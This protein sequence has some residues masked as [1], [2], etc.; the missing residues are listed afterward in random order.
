MDR[1]VRHDLLLHVLHTVD[2]VRVLCLVFGP[3]L[4]V[5]T[6]ACAARGVSSSG[7]VRKAGI[8]HN[9][10]VGQVLPG[11]R[12]LSSRASH[13]SGIAG[14]DIL[15]REHGGSFSGG[16]RE[17]VGENLGGGEGP[18]R[19]ALLL[20][21]DGMDESLP[22]IT[23]IE[24]VGDGLDGVVSGRMSGLSQH[25]TSSGGSEQGTSV[26]EGHVSEELVVSSLPGVSI[27]VQGINDIRVV[28]LLCL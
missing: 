23:S 11:V 16:N 18:A 8:G 21:S 1:S 4:T 6:F 20:I 12:K 25:H 10:L 24:G 13:I 9:T 7:S 5:R 26:G 17:S 27:L 22:M 14:H 28:D 19:S 3:A 15:S 2:G